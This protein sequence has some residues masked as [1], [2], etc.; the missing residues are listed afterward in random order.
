M[1]IVYVILI[2]SGIGAAVM[3]AAL[4]ASSKKS[5]M[6][7]NHAAMMDPHATVEDARDFIATMQLGSTHETR[8]GELK[9]TVQVL[10]AFAKFR[11][12]R[13]LLQC[14]SAFEREELEPTKKVS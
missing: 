7:Y 12:D 9:P 6:C 3:M 5:E 4:I 11:S 8:H 1:P 10:V 14:E 13:H 2:T